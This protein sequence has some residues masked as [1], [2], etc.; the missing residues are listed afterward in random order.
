M[1]CLAGL[2]LFLGKYRGFMRDFSQRKSYDGGKLFSWKIYRE[3]L[4]LSGIFS[5]R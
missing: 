3:R 4:K 5:P 2:F 1:P